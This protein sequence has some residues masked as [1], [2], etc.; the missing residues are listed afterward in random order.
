MI[1]ALGQKRPTNKAEVINAGKGVPGGSPPAPPETSLAEERAE[2]VRLCSWILAH[3]SFEL[4]FIASVRDAYRGALR[5]R[6]REPWAVKRARVGAHIA[7][8]KGRSVQKGRAH[9]PTLVIN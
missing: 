9:T 6:R 2:S 7:R 8:A 3:F 1:D 4:S 5:R